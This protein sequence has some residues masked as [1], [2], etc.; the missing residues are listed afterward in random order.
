MRRHD[1]DW[2][3]LVAGLVFATIGVLALTI[4]RQRFSDALGVIWSTALLGLGAALLLRSAREDRA[5]DE[6]RA[7]RGEDREVQE[8]GGGHHG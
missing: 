6:V 8:P 7:E 5:S 1:T 3:S 4:S 2:G